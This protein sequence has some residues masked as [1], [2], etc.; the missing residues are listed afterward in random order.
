MR[1]RKT[2]LR[3]T[4]HL[5]RSEKCQHVLD[6]M[7]LV[8]SELL[9][10]THVLLKV[11]LVNS[12]EASQLFL[13]HFPDVVVFDRKQDES[14]RVFLQERLRKRR[15]SVLSVCILRNR[16]LAAAW[17]LRADGV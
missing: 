6:E 3:E 13:V 4:R 2:K 7:L 12:P 8:G 11:H 5:P 17:R 1:E 14:V 15:L 10:V 16:D 9:P